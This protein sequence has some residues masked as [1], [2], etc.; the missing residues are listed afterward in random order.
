MK[1]LVALLAAFMLAIAIPALAARPD[2]P[3]EPLEV[4]GSQKTVKF[5][6][7]PHE[8]VDCA[9]CHHEVNGK[10][11]YQKCADAGCHDDLKAKKGEKSLYASIHT[12]TGLKHQ[13]CL[14]CH[15]KLVAEK[16]DKKKDMTGC[17]KSKCHP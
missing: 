15:T 2:V 12:K 16:P 9:V 17:A 8:K 5:P 3:K 11:N 7:A 10:E 14:E 6:H 1:S 4:K 13:T